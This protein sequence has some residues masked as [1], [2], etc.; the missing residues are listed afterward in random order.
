M[1]IPA[2]RVRLYLQ[3]TLNCSDGHET[4]E[5]KADYA[6]QRFCWFCGAEGYSTYGKLASE[7]YPQL[8]PD[9]VQ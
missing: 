7:T 5:W 4:V 6:D 3:I 2:D 8:M 9:P 1:S